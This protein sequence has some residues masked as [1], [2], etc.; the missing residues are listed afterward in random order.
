MKIE[1]RGLPSTVDI[2]MIWVMMVVHISEL[3]V[4]VL[5]R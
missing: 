2:Y 3:M 4:V 1:V 5:I